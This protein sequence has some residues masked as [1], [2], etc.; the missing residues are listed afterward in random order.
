[1]QQAEAIPIP[2]YE[3]RCSSIMKEAQI[4]FTIQVGEDF[5]RI[6]TGSEPVEEMWEEI[7]QEYEE[8]GLEN[9]IRTVNERMRERSNM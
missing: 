3:P 1:M 6:M 8:A 5:V 4:D 9:V 2:E 7:R